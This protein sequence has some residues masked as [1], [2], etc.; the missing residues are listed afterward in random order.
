MHKNTHAHAH[1]ACT[2]LLLG[3]GRHNVAHVLHGL[4]EADRLMLY[5]ELALF[6]GRH[7]QD[8]VDDVQQVVAARFVGIAACIHSLGNAVQQVAAARFVGAV[9]R[10]CFH[11]LWQWYSGGS[12]CADGCYAMIFNCG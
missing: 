5:G 2:Y 7:V 12:C 1:A 4:S 11:L 6:Q 8:V 9:P 3:Q 10:I